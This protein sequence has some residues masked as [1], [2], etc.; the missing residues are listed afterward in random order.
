M[1]FVK[2][3]E[4]IAAIRAVLTNVEFVGGEVLAVDFLS[5][6]EVIA[7]LLPP[8]LSPGRRPRVR[9]SVGRW[10]SN[11]VGD[12]VSATVLVSA[13]HG[14]TRGDYVLAMYMDGDAP[15]I[16]GREVFGE[17]KKL[18]RMGLFKQGGELAGTVER[19]G[20]TIMRLT[21][22][23]GDDEGPLE[24][25]AV[26]FNYQVPWAAD[27]S[28][29]AADATLT[30]AT[31]ATQVRVLRRGTA[32]VELAGTPHDPLDELPVAEVLGA[33]YTEADM[34]VRC[35]AAATVPAADFTPY[36]YGRGYDWAALRTGRPVVAA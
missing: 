30:E 17:P 27:G 23:V 35:R 25:G 4:E 32:T 9:V 36:A 2:T 21:G 31:F 26:S 13:L 22:E 19:G 7:E 14:E 29:L 1:G 16:F 12:F 11:C 24:G 10:R 34:A 20:T 18:A 15:L 5:E 3:P 33:M 8:P 28:G 6:P